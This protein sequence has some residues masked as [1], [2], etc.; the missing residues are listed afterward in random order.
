MIEGWKSRQFRTYPQLPGWTGLDWSFLLIP[1][2]RALIGAPLERIVAEQWATTT[3]ILL[4]DLAALPTGRWLSV[5][6]ESVVAD[7][8]RQI[9]RICEDLGLA[10]DRPLGRELPLSR[11]TYSKP[12]PE[13]WRAHESAIEATRSIWC[14]PAERADA[15]AG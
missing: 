10:W 14:E 11:H 9:A 6:H 7:P 5:S 3:R 8:A 15:V 2:W 12:A 1:D 4:D 13:K